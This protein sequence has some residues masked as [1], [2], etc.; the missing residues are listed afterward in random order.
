M[1]YS[2]EEKN[3]IQTLKESGTTWKNIGEAVGE[4]PR[5][6]RAWYSRNRENF[7]LPPKTII[8]KRK[9]D[10][11]IG[12]AIKRISKGNQRFLLETL[13][14]NL[15]QFLDLIKKFQKSPLL[16]IFNKEMVLKL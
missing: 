15:V 5:K 16:T 6:L 9:T 14:L 8:K 2:V 12:S 13:W 3:T 1:T 7:D 10:G 4:S 11:R